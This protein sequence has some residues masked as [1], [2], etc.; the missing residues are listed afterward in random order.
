MN[1]Q[2]F[3]SAFEN[4]TLTSFPHRSHVHMAWLYLRRGGWEQGLDHIRDGIRKF[5]AAL[6]ASGKYH[7]TITCFWAAMV[8][9]AVRDLPAEDDFERFIAL[10]PH[11]LNGR[12]IEEYYSAARLGSTSARTEWLEADLKPLPAQKA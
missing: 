1:D 12:L 6:G 10:C 11:L 5:A 3:L 2:E 4:C 8:Y 7:E 9:A